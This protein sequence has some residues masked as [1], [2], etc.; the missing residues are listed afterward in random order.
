[1]L[2]KHSHLSRK[3]LAL[4][5]SLILVCSIS[6]SVVTYVVAQ[7]SVMTPL[8]ISGGVYPSAATYTVFVDGGVYYAK[9]AYGSIHDTSASFAVLTQS[10][11]AENTTIYLADNQHFTQTATIYINFNDV[12]IES[13]FASIDF[14][15]TSSTAFIVGEAA[16]ATMFTLRGISLTSTKS[17]N[18]GISLGSN[19]L[20]VLPHISGC[21]I[22]NFSTGIYSRLSDY[23]DCHDNYFMSN[24]VGIN[25]AYPG[26]DANIVNN[27]MDGTGTAADSVGI[28]VNS[29]GDIISSNHI[30]TYTYG[31]NMSTSQNIISENLLDANIVGVQLI[32]SS[33]FA[34]TISANIVHLCTLIGIE[35]KNGAFNNMIVGNDV[36]NTNTAYAN[37][38]LNIGCNN[39]TISN[40]V[41]SFIDQVPGQVITETGILVT[42]SNYNILNGNQANSNNNGIVLTGASTYNVL[43]GNVAWDNNVVNILNLGTF[44]QIHSSYN[45]T[46]FIT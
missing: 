46:T 22:F 17:G 35:L 11:I 6:S 16:G 43:V 42:T 23:L 29:G 18:T 12:T 20:S 15:A 30:R 10:L 26:G 40:N 2:S 33:A 3:S 19:F 34:N 39:N 28:S 1:M 8:T 37:I 27:H 9:D 44:N 38:W 24:Y 4:L 5:F 32:G 41:A 21:T 36:S 25:L 13:R 31:I 14:T 45:G 7:S